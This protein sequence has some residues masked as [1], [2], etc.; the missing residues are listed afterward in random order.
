[1]KPLTLLFALAL[2]CSRLTLNAQQSPVNDD[3]CNAMPITV[4]ETCNGVPNIDTDLAT[5]QPDEPV[6]ICPGSSSDTIVYNSVWYSFTA[7]AGPVYILAAPDDNSSIGLSYQM[8]LFTMNGEC[9]SLSSLELVDCNAPQVNLQTAPALLATLEEGQTYY[10]QISGRRASTDPNPF[11]STG[12]LSITE[13]AA[14]ANDDACNALSLELNADPQVFDNLG[15][16]I[17]PGEAAIAPP[18]GTGGPLAVND[19]GWA[20]GGTFIDHSVWFSF[21]APPGGGNVTIDLTGSFGIPGDFNTQVAVYEAEDC[22]DFSTYTL[23]GAADNRLPPGGGI[24]QISADLDLFC[25]EGSKTYYILVDGQNSFLFQPIAGQGYFSIQ[26][27]GA[28]T[29]PLGAGIIVEGPNCPGGSDGSLL[30]RGTGG[31]GELSYLWDTGDDTPAI[32]GSLSAGEYTL[33]ITDECG[34]E[35]V[36]TFTVPESYFPPLT[37]EAGTDDSAC[38]GST[39]EL[40]ASAAG[41]LPID[42]RRVFLHSFANS[43]NLRLVKTELERPELQDT[44]SSTLALFFTEM[45]FAGDELYAVSD[46]KLYRVNTSTG[47]PALIDTLGLPS[48]RD[49]SY[50]PSSGTLYCVTADGD[51]YEV[52]PATAATTF[53][54]ATGL[55]SI[56]QAAID[57]NATLYAL[58]NGQEMYSASLSDGMASLVAPFNANPLAVRGLEID[59]TDDKMYFTAQTVNG[60]PPT[61]TWQTMNEVDK[62]TGAEAR[63]IRDLSALLPTLAF[64]IQA[65]TAA[66]YQ[67]AWAPAA[68][69]DDPGSPTPV[70]TVEETTTL[71]LAVSDAC[72]QS[73][74]MVTVSRLPDAM[75]TIDTSLNMGDTYNGIVIEAD[76]SITEIFTAA[77]GCDSIVTTNIMAVINSVQ[78]NWG[79]GA[80]RLSP[81][82]ATATLTVITEGV[83]E[84]RAHL[85]VRGLDGRPLLSVPLRDDKQEL[86]VS[87]LPAGQYLLEIR[88]AGQFAVRR[89]VKM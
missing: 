19:D 15:A 27:R 14:P 4:G 41:G 48:V 71:T 83:R 70:F 82:P 65:R 59:P 18:P 85:F 9:S 87:A 58:T 12:C 50:V 37:A 46:N 1:M 32:A 11:S 29:Q 66:P 64:A 63:F 34:G 73:E 44:I 84:S 31:A 45:E 57:N 51:V 3:L 33:T 38:G 20:L 23:V 74:D 7:P 25:L 67:Y 56:N 21:T 86:D 30:V 62:A 40:N 80:I 60:F 47:E 55:E 88:S 6:F 75:T 2:L 28:A 13:V 16:T 17:Q 72:G 53:V 39:V 89:F 43:E 24:L 69:L 81:N 52:D 49:L 36:E 79:A 5:A 76:T 42:T 35:Y 68:G 26:A 61:Y 22:N 8:N 78:D 10:L 54:V 77:N